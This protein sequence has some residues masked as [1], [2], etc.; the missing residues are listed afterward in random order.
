MKLHRAYAACV[1]A[2]TRTPTK[3]KLRR[4]FDFDAFE[5]ISADL[6]YDTDTKRQQAMGMSN[7]VIARLRSGENKPGATFI[8]RMVEIGI[9]YDS[10]FPIQ[11]VSK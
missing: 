7:G 5:Q 4:E 8:Q 6:G 1:N 2:N 11:S 3:P 9:P 10:V